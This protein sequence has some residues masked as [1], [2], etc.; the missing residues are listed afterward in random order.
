[1]NSILT[2]EVPGEVLDIDY[3]E[4]NESNRVNLMARLS[5]FA[6][7]T[8][9][10]AKNILDLLARFIN[11]ASRPVIPLIVKLLFAMR[12]VPLEL[13]Q[14]LAEFYDG[15]ICVY[16]DKRGVPRNINNHVISKKKYPNFYP[17][18]D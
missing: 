5:E 13:A 1:M 9:R 15:E 7:K 16:R 18:K 6:M 4:L 11:A 3:E 2:T 8:Y 10:K 14:F 12:N 17:N